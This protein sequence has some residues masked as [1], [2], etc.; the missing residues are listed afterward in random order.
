ML[1]HVPLSCLSGPVVDLV[2]LGHMLS[3]LSSCHVLWLMMAH[4]LDYVMGLVL[5]YV[6]WGVG[7]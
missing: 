2:F 6:S 3:L 1:R 7:R 4:V 5:D